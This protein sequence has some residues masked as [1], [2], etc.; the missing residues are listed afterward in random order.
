MGQSPAFVT[1][2]G[3]KAQLNILPDD[4]RYDA[5]LS[6]YI[7]AAT[8]LVEEYRS[9]VFAL[10]PVVERLDL[11]WAARFTLATTPVNAITSVVR[12]SDGATLPAADLHIDDPRAG[13][14]SV[15][16]GSQVYGLVDITY[17]AGYATVPGNVILAGKIVV[18]YLF[19]SQQRPKVGPQPIGGNDDYMTPGGLGT[20]LPPAVKALLGG[21]APMIA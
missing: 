11:P 8:M 7:D 3:A 4:T 16:D 19:E 17:N 18:Q 20:G 13:E 21:R 15:I 2:P 5:E 1:L 14:V 6:E 9:E 12:V 10:R